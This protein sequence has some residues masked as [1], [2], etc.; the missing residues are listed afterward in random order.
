MRGKVGSRSPR[1]QWAWAGWEL[2]ALGSGRGVLKGLE[3]AWACG[4]GGGRGQARNLP[5]PSLTFPRCGLGCGDTFRAVKLALHLRCR[6]W[7][8]AGTQRP[9]RGHLALHLPPQ[10][11]VPPP[12]PRRARGL[13]N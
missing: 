8:A 4:A 3:P 7:A 10:L 6:V 9:L 5:A 1:R 11:P 13:R 2:R 12:P